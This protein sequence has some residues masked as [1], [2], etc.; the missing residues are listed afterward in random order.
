MNIIKKLNLSFTLLIIGIA[1]IVIMI[2]M[3]DK[4]SVQKYTIEN[5]REWKIWNWSQECGNLSVWYPQ[6]WNAKILSSGEQECN[7]EISYFP[8]GYSSFDG[9]GEGVVLKINYSETSADAQTTVEKMEQRI[10]KSL[11]ESFSPSILHCITQN[12]SEKNFIFLHCYTKQ[13]K[14]VYIIS[15]DIMEKTDNKYKNIVYQI[16]DSFKLI[17]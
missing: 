11:D 8:N 12:N 17:K 16:L 6:D 13:N 3:K 10:G 9:A 14:G 4:L 5:T 15:A 7:G 1:F 2:F